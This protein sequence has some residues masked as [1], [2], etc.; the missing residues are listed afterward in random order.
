MEA[1]AYNLS[2][3][4]ASLT[5]FLLCLYSTGA[6]RRCR[7][8]QIPWSIFVRACSFSCDAPQ[9]ASV[10]HRLSG[11]S[12]HRDP[13]SP[14]SSIAL[15]SIFLELRFRRHR[16]FQLLKSLLPATSH[17]SRY[18]SVPRGSTFQARHPFSSRL[19]VAAWMA[20]TR[21]ATCACPDRT[22]HLLSCLCVSASLLFFSS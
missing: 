12:T 6:S 3:L 2:H 7:S 11:G 14:L 8:K 5:V 15:F 16:V 9:I 18:V 1:P 17:R 13:Q 10:D 19:S 21:I 4:R 22:R 20:T